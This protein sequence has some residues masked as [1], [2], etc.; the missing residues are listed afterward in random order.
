MSAVSRGNKFELEAKKTLEAEGWEVFR[1]H[2]KPL[3]IKGRMVT[4]GAD[5]FGADLV[6]KKSGQRT[7]WIQVSTQ[8]NLAAKKNQL[9]DHVLVCNYEDYEVWIRVEGKKEFKVYVFC[10]PPI[11][12]FCPPD[13]VKIQENK[14]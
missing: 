10:G 14:R 5:I 9:L 12:D 8:S 2:R 7:K 3:F 1:Q 11:N 13:T 4:I 6:A